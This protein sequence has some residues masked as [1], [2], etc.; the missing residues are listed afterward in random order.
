[1]VF[2]LLFMDSEKLS[3]NCGWLEI[4]K[5]DDVKEA[6]S[7]A[8]ASLLWDLHNNLFIFLIFCIPNLNPPLIEVKL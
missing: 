6:E 1:M 7:R 8:D 4:V 5:I 2:I 3:S